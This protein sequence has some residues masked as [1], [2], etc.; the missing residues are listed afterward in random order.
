MICI[1]VFVLRVSCSQLDW[2][3]LSLAGD[4]SYGDNK[5]GERRTNIN[6]YFYQNISSWSRYRSENESVVWQLARSVQGLSSNINKMLVT[7][8][9]SR[10]V[11]SPWPLSPA[12]SLGWIPSQLDVRQQEHGSQYIHQMPVNQLSLLSLK[13]LQPGIIASGWWSGWLT[14]WPV[15]CLRSCWC[16]WPLAWTLTH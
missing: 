4:G 13:L 7:P 2:T 15:T 8:M 12:P 6:W 5:H 9:I 1:G 10:D 14:W 16:D 3:D 11:T